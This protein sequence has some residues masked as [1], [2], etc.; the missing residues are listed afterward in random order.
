MRKLGATMK[1]RAAKFDEWVDEYR[2]LALLGLVAITILIVAFFDWMTGSSLSQQLLYPKRATVADVRFWS[3]LVYTLAFALGLPVAFLI[4]HWRDRNARDQIEN[5]RKDI[6]LKEFQE[7]QL[8]AA[9][10][11]DEK[12]P[13]EAREQL[14]IAA[15]HQLRGF[16]RGEY[17]ESF[18]RPAFELFCAGLDQTDAL[19][20][21]EWR[22]KYAAE[23][24]DLGHKYTI[25]VD[26]QHKLVDKVSLTRNKII[27]EEW[28]D[29]FRSGFPLRERNF[30]F[31]SLPINADL[32]GL[33][34]SGC[35]FIRS[36]LDRVNFANSIMR[37][38]VLDRTFANGACFSGVVFFGSSMICSGL[39]TTTNDTLEPRTKSV[40]FSRADLT[41]VNLSYS[42]MLGAQLQGAK[43]YIP[44]QQDTQFAGCEFDSSTE[45]DQNWQQI[46]AEQK[47]A[48]RKIWLDLGATNVD[49]Q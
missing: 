42:V 37:F 43:I 38:A 28:H 40:D 4:W 13:A 44:R 5:A 25:Y 41:F 23:K 14:Q 12:L 27:S 29:I 45:F 2:P 30:S 15:L 33:D 16:L 35:R 21:G 48:K 19:S 7:V 49:H 18:K 24:E 34:L 8:R 9:G 22:E 31:V 20:F 3:A 39:S 36:G 47:E 6:N 11:L 26:G 46:P 17:G 10:A 1:S 32:S